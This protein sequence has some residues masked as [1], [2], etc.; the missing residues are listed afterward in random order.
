MIIRM[1]SSMRRLHDIK[2]G[3]LRHPIRLWDWLVFGPVFLV[4]F[5]MV[6]LHAF[7]L[8]R[9][10]QSSVTVAV[11]ED[12]KEQGWDE[13]RASDL[14]SWL[15]IITPRVA[16]R[17]DNR[18]DGRAFLKPYGFGEQDR[19]ARITELIRQD[20]KAVYDEKTQT[21]T[22]YFRHPD[23]KVAGEVVLCV[24]Q[25]YLFYLQRE[26]TTD[27][28]RLNKWWENRMLMIEA[29]KKQ[30]EIHGERLEMAARALDAFRNSHNRIEKKEPEIR[31]FRQ[32]DNREG[33]T[34]PSPPAEEYQRLAAAVQDAET[35]YKV[36]LDRL[37][38]LTMI[39]GPGR[40]PVRM[41]NYSGWAASYDFV[42]AP[43]IP[44]AMW[45]GLVALGCSVVAVVIARLTL[46]LVGGCSGH[47][48]TTS[49][50]SRL[51]DGLTKA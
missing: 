18:S 48:A 51:R 10:Y 8:L 2:G 23:F 24:G 17:F 27:R 3:V 35:G 28:A 31:G 41:V 21:T 1:F 16:R 33:E 37:R 42:F 5:A 4:V 15:P 12:A 34:D 13:L 36:H 7:P 19:L 44:R 49:S 46:C 11:A 25:E 9:I 14:P 40:P 32:G 30:T 43:I 45:G 38:D 26:E 39:T 6:L 20:L 29:Q 22:L 47:D 50:R